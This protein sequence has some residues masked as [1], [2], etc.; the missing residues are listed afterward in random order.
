MQDCLASG[1]LE[2]AAS[3][4]IILQNLE[5]PTV[6]K[7][8]ATILLDKA[9]DSCRWNIAQDLVR[10]LRCIG[11]DE[12]DSPPRSPTFV[13]PH[14]PP[15]LSPTTS[16]DGDDITYAVN[17][18]AR[19]TSVSTRASLTRGSSMDKGFI[20]RT[21]STEKGSL[22]RS[23]SMD[24]T[25]K[26]VAASSP[27]ST[28]QPK[29]P[30]ELETPDN[31]FIDT[32][33]NRHARLL[34]TA[35]RLRD[36]GKFAAHLDFGLV[37]W[38]RKEKNRA[39][40]V[41]DYIE[42][43]TSIHRNF[44]LPYPAVNQL[45]SAPLSPKPWNRYG[46]LSSVSSSSSARGGRQTLDELDGRMEL[47]IELGEEEL[48]EEEAHLSRFV[49][50]NDETGRVSGD[51]SE[52]SSVAYSMDGEEDWIWGGE[53]PGYV[54]VQE[55]RA[56]LAFSGSLPAL[57]EI[58]FLLQ[59]FIEA[60]CHDWWFILSLVLRDS[61][62]LTDF[63][64]DVIKLCDVT[65][66]SITRMKDGIASLEA[67]AEQNCHGYHLFFGLHKEHWLALERAWTEAKNAPKEQ[68]DSS[69]ASES[70]RQSRQSSTS[71][72]EERPGDE[73]EE[74]EEMVEEN[75]NEYEC[76]VS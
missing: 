50:V 4:L 20:T 61:T 3:Y 74:Y 55:I 69:P 44:D 70:G 38:L 37:P 10:F 9:L 27:T 29:R 71:K 17:P 6:S 19:S 49:E 76:V 57:R 31:F 21:P 59:M 35:T 58:R 5:Q 56:Q 41:D 14:H 32:I 33:L 40:R 63:I 25:R 46:R 72:D 54:D 16:V 13:K 22:S 26:T 73:E 45:T 23:G 2:T 75:K 15:P 34:L 53:G 52:T 11:A 60:K 39:A 30:M 68:K 51:P 1:K 8:H 12:L 43:L 48:E 24:K 65:V 42:T 66:D 18:H 36:L 67:W 64:D 28:T 62:C 47:G 7:Q